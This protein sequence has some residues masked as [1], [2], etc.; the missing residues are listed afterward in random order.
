VSG[1]VSYGLRGYRETRQVRRY[2][3]AVRRAV[4]TV[5]F[6]REQCAAAGAV[7][8]EARPTPV[9][10]L[11][12]PPHT[13]C[14]FARPWWGAYEPPLWLRRP[15]ALARALRLAGCGGDPPVLEVRDALLDCVHLPGA[16]PLHRRRRYAVLLA[17]GAVVASPARRAQLNAE[18]LAVAAAAGGAWVVGGHDE[19]GVPELRESGFRPVYRMPVSAAADTTPAEGPVLLYEPPLGYLGALVPDCQGYHLDWQRVHARERDGTVTFSLLRERRP[20]L[21]DIV[22]PGADV[23]RVAECRRHGSPMLRARRSKD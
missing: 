8:G 23:V 10:D 15:A 14:P 9:A 12:D 2:R 3:R 18:A 22:P 6:Y 7:T 11:P 20:T 21:L 13:L 17:S 1:G 5:T 19:L 16:T 4:S